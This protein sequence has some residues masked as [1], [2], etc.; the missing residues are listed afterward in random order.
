MAAST[1]NGNGQMWRSCAKWICA[2]EVLP[3]DKVSSCQEL[4]YSL[5]DGVLLC[6]IA[7]RLD[8]SS[9]QV[10]SINHKT[11][12]SQFLSLQN[13]K[14]FL[15]ACKNSFGLQDSELFE[16]SMLWYVYRN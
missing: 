8:E 1:E 3:P 7:S 16:A 4:A 5:R 14:L 9:I 10:K 11:A 15:A 12:Q 2:L 13:I 6:H